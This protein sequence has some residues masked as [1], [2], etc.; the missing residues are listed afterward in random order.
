MDQE[1]NTA[2][3][4]GGNYIAANGRVYNMVDLLGGGT[5]LGDQVYDVRQYAPKCGLVLGSDGRVYDLTALLFA[6]AHRQSEPQA[7]AALPE[8]TPKAK[9]ARLLRESDRAM[10]LDRLGLCVPEGATFK[11]W[12][13]FLAALG[14]ALTG[15]VAAYRQALYELPRHPQW[16]D[17]PPE[18]W[19]QMP[20]GLQQDE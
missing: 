13:P 9:R 1:P 10:A 16:P 18:A 3:P 11:A 6:A 19:P 12:E 7:A 17:V 5:P 14:A 4:Q 20:D 8:E 2:S 15:E